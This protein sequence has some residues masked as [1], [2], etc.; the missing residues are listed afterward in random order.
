MLSPPPT[1]TADTAL[2]ERACFRTNM[3]F[4]VEIQ[5]WTFEVTFIVVLGKAQQ[6]WEVTAEGDKSNAAQFSFKGKLSS[7]QPGWVTSQLG[8]L[9]ISY[10]NGKQIT[11]WWQFL[12]L[13]GW[14]V[15]F[16]SLLKLDILSCWLEESRVNKN[17]SGLIRIIKPLL[18]MMLFEQ[19]VHNTPY[20]LCFPKHWMGRCNTLAL[21]VQYGSH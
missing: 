15:G 14:A 9:E 1:L 6:R 4:T 13:L 12:Q 17:V 20:L 5:P 10:V 8:Q 2:F 16:C 19:R 21:T 7:S 18:E 11:E 3:L